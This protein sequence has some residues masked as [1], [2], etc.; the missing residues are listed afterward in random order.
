MNFI[1][2]GDHCAPA[3]LLKELG[4]RQQ[5]YP[6]DWYA[7]HGDDPSRSVLEMNMELLQELL[8]TGDHCAVRDKLL[9]NQVTEHNRV[10]G[11]VV[12]AHE[13][14][15]KEEI[16]AKYA[17]RFQRLYQDISQVDVPNVFVMVVRTHVL[18]GPQVQ[19]WVEWLV[20]HNPA[21]HVLLFSGV[22]QPLCTFSKHLSFFL[23]PFDFSHGWEGDK[24]FRKEIRQLLAEW[25]RG[26]EI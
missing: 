3:I 16:N 18:D 2:L 1:P 8:A 17:R 20:S 15:T 19:A 7:A 5:A 13:F 26:Q 12:F 21:N 24:P 11:D 6:F 9:Q 22:E 23:V 10:L 4:L 14:G 25:S